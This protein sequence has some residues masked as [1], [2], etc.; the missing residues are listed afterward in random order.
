MKSLFNFL[1]VTFLSTTLLA[2]PIQSSIE[3]DDSRV[4]SDDVVSIEIYG[5]EN[6]KAEKLYKSL[7]KIEEQSADSM[8]ER[9]GFAKQGKAIT[10]IVENDSKVTNLYSCYI[11]IS[12][13][14]DS[15]EP[16][17]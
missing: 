9:N 10:C 15:L 6:S 3:V 16:S 11:K 4:N 2:N 1:I 5:G 8:G 14:G 12:T 13:S 7:N 17:F